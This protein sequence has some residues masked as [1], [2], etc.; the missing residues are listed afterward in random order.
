M[1]ISIMPNCLL[2]HKTHATQY[3]F[4]FCLIFWR[5]VERLPTPIPTHLVVSLLVVFLRSL[6]SVFL[7]SLSSLLFL[8]YFFVFFLWPPF[9]CKFRKSRVQICEMLR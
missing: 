7:S 3:S 4:G 2:H 9:V 8:S 5:E 6:S 1:S